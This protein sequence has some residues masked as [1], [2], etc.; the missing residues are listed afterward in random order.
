M[1]DKDEDACVYVKTVKMRQEEKGRTRPSAEF[2]RSRGGVQS[3]T[4]RLVLG[5]EN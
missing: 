4:K 5:C 2:L 1:S 3:F